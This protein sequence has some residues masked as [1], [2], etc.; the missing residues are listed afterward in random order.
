MDSYDPRGAW[1]GSYQRWSAP[2][3]S[4][5]TGNQRQRQWQF[6]SSQ[7]WSNPASAGVNSGFQRPTWGAPTAGAVEEACVVCGASHSLVEC[8]QFQQ[9]PVEQ[10]RDCIWTFKRCYRCCGAGHRAAECYVNQPCSICGQSFHHSLLHPNPPGGVDRSSAAPSASSVVETA[11]G[12]KLLQLSGTASAPSAPA[13]TP[14]A[15]ADNSHLAAAVSVSVVDG[16]SGERRCFRPILPVRVE[17]ES[18]DSLTTYA[19][20]DS[21]SNKT[22]MTELTPFLNVGQL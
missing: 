19:L 22:V 6:H 16:G 3:Q 5:T 12:Q 11:T 2:R 14:S 13:S 17:F 21:G 1:G 20:L 10:R 7:N 18:G 9:L 4:W 15:P 8:D